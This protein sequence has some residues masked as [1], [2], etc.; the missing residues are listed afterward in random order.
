MN[1]LLQS[2]YGNANKNAYT[3]QKN[4]GLFLEAMSIPIGVWNYGNEAG[5]FD[6]GDPNSQVFLGSLLPRPGKNDS[7]RVNH[8]GQIDK[9][10]KLKESAVDARYVMYLT[11]D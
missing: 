1:V 7:I 9:V 6:P 8:F 11:E 10:D 2:R 4:A 3:I 5:D